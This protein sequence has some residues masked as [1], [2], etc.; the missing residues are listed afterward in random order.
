MATASF[1]RRQW[2]SNSLRVT[3]KE[4]SIVNKNTAI[5]ERFS[6]YQKAAEEVES[7]R[8]SAESGSL[9]PRCGNLNDL[10]RRWEQPMAAP[11]SPSRELAP[12]RSPR[13]GPERL[14]AAGAESE[15]C[16]SPDGC[17]MDAT[18]QEAVAPPAGTP[19]TPN[20]PLNSLKMMFERGD[21]VQNRVPLRMGASRSVPEN[22]ALQLGERDRGVDTIPLRDRMALYQAAVSKRDVNVSPANDGV[23]VDH[24]SSGVRQKENVETASFSEP[25]SRKGSATDSN[26]SCSTVPPSPH[27]SAQAKPSRTFR[28][29]VRESCVV[30][31]KTVYPLERLVADQQVYHS[32]CFR[33]AHCNTRL[34]LGNY[35]SLH[36]HI[37]CKPHFCQ[38]FKAKGNYDEG[39][40][41]RPHKEQWEARAESRPAVPADGRPGP[42]V[43]ESHIGKVNELMAT[44]ETR[45]RSCSPEK[46]AG[47]GAER[48]VETGRLKISW[49]PRTEAPDGATSPVGSGQASTSD[50]SPT[51]RPVRAKWPPDSDSLPPAQSPE[52][53]DLFGLRRSSSLKERSRPDA[54]TP[55]PTFKPETP[56]D[57][58]VPD[59][60]SEAEEPQ[61]EEHADDNDEEELPTL[62]YQSTSLDHSP[63]ASPSLESSQNRTSQDVGFWD[64]E[65]ES[66]EDTMEDVI[67]RNRNYE[68]EDDDDDDDD[69]D[70]EEQDD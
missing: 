16:H 44:L 68:E 43:E 61:E 36:N 53:S 59:S 66:V 27:D 2:A 8:R 17:G 42:T 22:M 62:K 13:A 30:C 3:A 60:S 32:A 28:P 55:V 29:A 25:S 35:A 38:L 5:A 20:V 33:C 49:P 45:A 46:P 47:V 26:G 70:D 51:V 9:G 56:Q 31:L 39:F 21:N 11:V 14:A 6:K 12:E 40:G 19:E 58:R 52:Q 1:Q 65:E 67:K 54:L 4:L 34:S 10:K 63:P 41:Y 50:C 57:Q 69:D 15:C 18:Q 37:Y 24:G 7:E 64:G 48:P 23:D